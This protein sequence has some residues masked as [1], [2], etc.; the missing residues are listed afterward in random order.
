MLI[1]TAALRE[2]DDELRLLRWVYCGFIAWSSA[3]TYLEART[4][5]DLH[6]ALL[7]GAE[8]VA[9]AAFLFR[10][11]EIPARAVLVLIYAIAAVLVSLQGNVPIRFLD[12]GATAIYIVVASRA[13]PAKDRFVLA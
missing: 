8:F 10:R 3:R 4:A 9:I 2:D 1:S 11:L 6:P 13:Q 7:A 5:H 12:Y